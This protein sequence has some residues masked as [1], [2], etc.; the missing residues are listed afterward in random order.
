MERLKEFTDPEFPIDLEPRVY[1]TNEILEIVKRKRRLV[2]EIVE[3]GILLTGDEKLI[4]KIK[5]EYLTK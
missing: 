1:T 2:K 5:R 4:E 3:Y